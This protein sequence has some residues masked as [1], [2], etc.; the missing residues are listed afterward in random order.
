MSPGVRY[1]YSDDILQYFEGRQTKIQKTNVIYLFCST[2]LGSVLAKT[3]PF[4]LLVPW[5]LVTS[6]RLGLGRPLNVS[7]EWEEKNE[8]TKKKQRM[9]KQEER[10]KRV[11]ASEGVHGH[12]QARGTYARS[13]FHTN[14]KNK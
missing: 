1:W 9:A 2:L 10:N 11:C 6:K 13:C 5:G 14:K 4:Q 7:T 8:R 3:R 12:T